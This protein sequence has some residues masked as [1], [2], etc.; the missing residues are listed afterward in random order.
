VLHFSCSNGL[1]RLLSTAFFAPSAWQEG[2]S[3][4]RDMEP[5]SHFLRFRS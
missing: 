1:E 4:R 5:M 3:T 2:D